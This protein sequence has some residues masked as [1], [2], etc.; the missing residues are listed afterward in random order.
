MVAN[1]SLGHRPE[2]SEHEKLFRELLP[3]PI[4]DA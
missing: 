4:A 1:V 3:E 2:L